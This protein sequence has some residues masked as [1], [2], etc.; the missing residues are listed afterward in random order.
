MVFSL[1]FG[2][3]YFFLVAA[4]IVGPSSTLIHALQRLSTDASH[5]L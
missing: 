2:L 5:G 3:C 4:L 1:W